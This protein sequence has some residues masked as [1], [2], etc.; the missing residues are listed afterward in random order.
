MFKNVFTIGLIAL[1][2]AATTQAMAADVFVTSKGKKFHTED[3]RLIKN[4]ATTA[5]DD[6][7]AIEKG[8]EPCKVCHK[9]EAAAQKPSKE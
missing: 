7:E 9:S 4:K 8:L 3:C 2:L 1:L 6:K 5:I